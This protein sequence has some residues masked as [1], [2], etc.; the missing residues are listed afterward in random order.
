MNNI[1][2]LIDNIKDDINNIDSEYTYNG[3]TVPRVTKI[4]SRCIHNDS[5]MY[6]ANSLGFKHQ[7]YAKVINAKIPNICPN[8]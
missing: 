6:W 2:E 5:L 4:I 8:Q 7:S 1:I 3:T